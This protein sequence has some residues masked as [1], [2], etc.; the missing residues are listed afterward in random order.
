MRQPGHR[1]TLK[2]FWQCTFQ[3][4][5]ETAGANRSTTTPL[6]HGDSECHNVI[7]QGECIH[8][9]KCI[10]PLDP[11]MGYERGEFPTMGY[12]TVAYLPLLHQKTEGFAL[13]GGGQSGFGTPSRQPNGMGTIAP[14]QADKLFIGWL[15]TVGIVDVV[16]IMVCAPASAHFCLAYWM[17]DGG[18]KKKLQDSHDCDAVFD[19]FPPTPP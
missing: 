16:V 6:S 10:T 3:N 11:S 13:G 19:R 15:Y 17:K 2:R 1:Q 14:H 12:L 7:P 5:T 4:G 8:A 9:P 18:I